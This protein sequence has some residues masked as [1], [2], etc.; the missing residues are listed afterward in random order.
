MQQQQQQ[1]PVP[2]V[3]IPRLPSTAQKKF[4]N[5][6]TPETKLAEKRLRDRSRVYLGSQSERWQEVRDRNGLKTSEDMAKFLLDSYEKFGKGSSS[7]KLQKTRP[8][9][10]DYPESD[11]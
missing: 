9:S 6:K 10:S 5:F 1:H 2:K 3:A 11:E 4:R 8:R 7:Q